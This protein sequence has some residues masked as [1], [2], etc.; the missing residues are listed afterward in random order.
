MIW[1]LRCHFKHTTVHFSLLEKA[2]SKSSHQSLRFVAVYLQARNQHRPRIDFWLIVSRSCTFHSPRTVLASEPTASI[3]AML[4]LYQ[5]LLKCTKILFHCYSLLKENM[6]HA[7]HA[8]VSHNLCSQC[9]RLV[10]FCYVCCV[11]I[12][13]F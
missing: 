5:L 4:V 2:I 6:R 1:L 3:F 12:S 11:I 8:L 13:K 9:T 7:H 10:T